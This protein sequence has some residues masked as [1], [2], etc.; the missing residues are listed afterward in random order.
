[1]ELRHFVRMMNLS[2]EELEDKCGYE[3]SYFKN[4]RYRPVNKMSADDVVAIANALNIDF[5]KLL[6]VVKN[7]NKAINALFDM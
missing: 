7:H 5:F 2:Y 4:R 3:K 6:D 1:M